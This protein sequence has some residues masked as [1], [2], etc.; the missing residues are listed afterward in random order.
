MNSKGVTGFLNQYYD[1]LI[2]A[3]VMV[4]LFGC[5]V[6]LLLRVSGIRKA[7]EN[8][9][10]PV[11]TKAQI[12]NYDRAKQI[13]ALTQ[14]PPAWTT[15]ANHRVFI[16]PG[17]KLDKEGVPKIYDI[18]N[19]KTPGGI[20]Y[21][22][23]DAYNESVQGADVRDSDGDGYTNLEEFCGGSN[24]K[25]PKKHPDPIVKLRIEK[26]I[27]KTFPFVLDVIDE[28]G[29][30]SGK[31]FTLRRR[32]GGKSYSVKINDTVPDLEYPGYKVINCSEK[33]KEEP[34]EGVKDAAGKTVIRRTSVPCL[35]LQKEGEE[36]VVLEKGK[37][38]IFPNIFAKLYFLLENRSFD[39]G[40]KSRFTLQDQQYE[41]IRIN[42]V[43]GSGVKVIVKG[44]NS[45]EEIEL[46]QLTPGDRKKN[47]NTQH[48][49]EGNG[50]PP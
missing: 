2:A 40:A 27:P 33:I 11:Q 8:D 28:L 42:K 39:V 48:P 12:G 46:L 15:N 1:R 24:P 20:P 7:I 25:D 50:F 9:P 32:E 43:D 41:V 47:P 17:I 21:T 31:S 36:P 45:S 34:M 19:I 38:G 10:K 3:F 35:T 26:P 4:L 29:E 30:G 5:S 16:A 22:W 44:F 37:E 13:Q 14:A 49:A 18:S 23:L 6:W